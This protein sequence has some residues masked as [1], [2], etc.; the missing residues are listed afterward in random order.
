M[1]PSIQD[2]CK[3]INSGLTFTSIFSVFLVV[4]FLAGLI[5][6]IYH[7]ESSLKKPIL[8][9]EAIDVK[10]SESISDSFAQGN[11][12]RPFGSSKG[13]TYTFAWCQGSDRIL[14]K[15]KVYFTSENQAVA[16]GRTL[17]KLCKR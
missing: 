14:E 8:Y 10:A 1:G 15:N 11:N 9:T 13:K 6:Y 5:M 7:Q 4:V 16:S 2:Y 17:S 12:S 3:K